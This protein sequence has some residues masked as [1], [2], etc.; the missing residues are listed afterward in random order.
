MTRTIPGPPAASAAGRQLTGPTYVTPPPPSS[1][2]RRERDG[3]RY[4]LG[5]RPLPDPQPD[6]ERGRRLQQ[7]RP[8]QASAGHRYA[9]RSPDQL[10]HPGQ[11]RRLVTAQRNSRRAPVKPET[12]TDGVGAPDLV[13]APY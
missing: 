1:E 9:A 6:E 7:G 13:P 11:C 2:A 12:R 10:L 8:L 5:V 3:R 4:R